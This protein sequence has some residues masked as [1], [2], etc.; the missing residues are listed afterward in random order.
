VSRDEPVAQAEGGTLGLSVR[1]LQRDELRRSGVDHGLLVE[2]VSGAA[3]Q[4]GIEAGDVLLALNGK[5]VHSVEQIHQA[6]Q[7]HPKHVALLIDRDG[8]RIFVPVDI[9]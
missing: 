8:Q 6:L 9:G 5:P 3:A 2:N 7:A 1:P 4:A